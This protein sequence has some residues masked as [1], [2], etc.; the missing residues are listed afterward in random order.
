MMQ[1]TPPKKVVISGIPY[2]IFVEFKEKKSS[3]VSVRDQ[4]LVFRMSSY[5]PEI[6]VEEEFLYLLNSIRRK[7]GKYPSFQKVPF[8]HILQKGVLKV[9]NISFEFVPKDTS[10]TYL[11]EVGV[12][13]FPFKALENEELAQKVRVFTIK[14]I[15]KL[16][17]NS[18]V[19]HLHN[20]NNRT[21]KYKINNVEVKYS[22]S[23]WGHCTH[24]NTIMLNI[25]LISA[26]R[27]VVEYVMAHEISHI[28]YKDHSKQ[29]WMEV[30]R[31]CPN[32]KDLRKEL[33]Q[34]SSP[35]F[36]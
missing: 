14:L 13:A 7:I 3:S 36:D 6:K 34:V 15:L 28:K 22:V 19:E 26:P 5:L 24:S 16:Y 21:Y 12:I 35:L 30:E 33:S 2:T 32:Y 1:F 8:C 17:K 25:K 9:A 29:F 11:L 31:F 27:E 20:F 23:K 4:N 18:L 10:R